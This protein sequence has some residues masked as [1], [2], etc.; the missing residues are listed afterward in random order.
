MIVCTT[1]LNKLIQ[2]DA[3]NLSEPQSRNKRLRNVCEAQLTVR[4]MAQ[5][6]EVTA[7]G[8]VDRKLGVFWTPTVGIFLRP[9]TE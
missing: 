7:H 8:V 6:Q 3:L 9:E 2:A 1:L 5:K 4:H